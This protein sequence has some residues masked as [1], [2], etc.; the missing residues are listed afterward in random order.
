MRKHI[1]IGT[2][3]LTLAAL[4]VPAAASA[5]GPGASACQ[6]VAGQRTAG[7]AQTLGGLGPVASIVATSTPG[8]I[9][10]MNQQDLF[11]CP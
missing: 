1:A 2:A 3:A 7:F 11:N 6:P 5:Q 10:A 8:A 4:G 9:A